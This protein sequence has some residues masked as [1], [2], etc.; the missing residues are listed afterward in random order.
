[1]STRKVFNDTGKIKM[2]RNYKK[3]KTSWATTYIVLS[4]GTLKKNRPNKDKR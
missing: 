4:D 3:E 2:K 1:M